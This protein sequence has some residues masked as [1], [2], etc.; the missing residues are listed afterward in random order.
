MGLERKMCGWIS[1]WKKLEKVDSSV[2]FMGGGSWRIWIVQFG[3][4]LEDEFVS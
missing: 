4:W 2:W 1:G 3:F